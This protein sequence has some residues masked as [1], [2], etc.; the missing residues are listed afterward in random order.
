[1]EDLIRQVGRHLKLRQ[2]ASA[3][4]IEEL[5]RRL[6]VRLP[7]D[8]LAFLSKSDGAEGPIGASS[9]VALCGV[10]EVVA[11]NEGLGGIASGLL[12]F[13]SDGGEAAYAFELRSGAMHVVEIP[14]EVMD[15]HQPVVI[16]ESFT[17]FLHYLE[18]N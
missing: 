1:M 13:G 11:E 16:A 10:D 3:E 4:A 5:Q 7:Q 17:E 8:Y 18:R 12:I 6:G 14:F 2:G 15:V 9:Y